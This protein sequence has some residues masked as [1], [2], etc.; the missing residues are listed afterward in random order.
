MRVHTDSC[1]NNSIHWGF[2]G[3][4][5]FVNDVELL[6]K[7]H[8]RAKKELKKQQKAIT[9]KN[10]SIK[11]YKE[12]YD[13]VVKQYSR[14]ERTLIDIQDS[15]LQEYEQKIN[16]LNN[17]STLELKLACLEQEN[18]QL[19]KE[20]S[21]SET[22]VEGRIIQSMNDTIITLREQLAEAEEKYNELLKQIINE[23]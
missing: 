12:M 23:K 1:W 22:E 6:D 8:K 17:I 20:H 21:K 4:K 10:E 9:R 16:Q 18:K 19:R 7:A 15:R 2:W 11:C 13:N 5:P 14:L 3:M